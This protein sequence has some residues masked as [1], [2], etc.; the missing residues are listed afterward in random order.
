MGKEVCIPVK[1]KG[2]TIELSV[3][4]AEYLIKQLQIAVTNAEFSD[5]CSFCENG[6]NNVGTTCQ[7]CNGSGLLIQQKIIKI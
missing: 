5:K 2:C 6:I 1:L 4:E 3:L 7:Y